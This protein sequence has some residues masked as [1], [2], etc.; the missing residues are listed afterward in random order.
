MWTNLKKI[1]FLKKKATWI[2]WF[3]TTHLILAAI[4]LLSLIAFGI[5]PT[6]L[7][8]VIGAPMWVAVTILSKYITDKVVA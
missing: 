2:G 3:V 7:V 1:P 8:S 5:N 4:I 6:L